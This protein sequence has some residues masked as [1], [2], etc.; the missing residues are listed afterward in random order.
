MVDEYIATLAFYP[1]LNGVAM[2]P[3]SFPIERRKLYEFIY[4]GGTVAE[5]A[6]KFGVEDSLAIMRAT[7]DIV[8][9]ERWT[10]VL[11]ESAKKDEIRRLL[12]RCAMML[13]EHSAAEV[14]AELQSI[15][16]AGERPIAVA[17]ALRRC[18]DADEVTIMPDVVSDGLQGSRLYILAARPGMGKT[19]YALQ[20]FETAAQNGCSPIFF[21]LEMST[22]QICRRLA[23]RGANIPI[24]R[25]DKT[26]IAD[27]YYQWEP[28]RA[29][30]SNQSSL[31]DIESAI[32]QTQS[33]VVFID[34]LQLMTPTDRKLVR[35]QQ[36]AELSRGLKK[37]AVKYSIAIVLLAQLSRQVELRPDKRPQLS[38]LRESGAIEQD[39]DQVWLM[40]R[41]SYYEGLKDSNGNDIPRDLGKIILAKNR[42]GAT[43]DWVFR[44]NECINRF[45]FL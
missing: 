44:T 1:H 15:K 26:T 11:R 4:N 27:T 31:A 29:F 9:F 45:D 3:E 6:T 35:E 41:P 32:C 12:T 39:A 30:V 13:N 38:D 7:P 36:V 40:Y 17:D 42:D 25:V 8:A 24:A 23:S 34:Y 33:R 18:M 37:L 28:T 19:S 43:R 22:P 20:L 21:S 2:E 16:P 10:G 14:L 5:L